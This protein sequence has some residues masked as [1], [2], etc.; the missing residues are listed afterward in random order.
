MG[1]GGTTNKKIDA[2]KPV[3]QGPLTAT[4]HTNEVAQ[5]LVALA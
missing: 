5:D 3:S 4:I 1:D 2:I